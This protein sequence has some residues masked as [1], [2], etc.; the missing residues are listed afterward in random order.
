MARTP[1]S[2]KTMADKPMWR[3]YL[4]FWGADA[5]A[6]IDNEISFHLEELVKQSTA[7]VKKTYP[8]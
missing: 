1:T 6:D 2:A 8:S 5:P 4:R 7:F 3:R